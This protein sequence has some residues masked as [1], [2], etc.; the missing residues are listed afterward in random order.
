MADLFDKRGAQFYGA[1][2]VKLTRL[3]NADATKPKIR[4]ALADVAKSASPQDVLIVFLAGHGT[5]LGQRYYFIPHEF[6]AKADQMETDIREQGLPQDTIGDMLAAV[7]ALKR[8]LI[9]DTC[10]SGGA[11]PISRT[12]RDPFAFRGALERLSHATGTFTIAA[13]AADNQAHEVPELKHGLLTYAL[14]AGMGAV[15]NGPLS[16][17]AIRPASDNKVAD[18][19]EW[20]SFAQDKVP[21]LTKLYFGEEQFVGFSGQGNSFPL[22]PVSEK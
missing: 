12:A 7:P 17:Q 8:V 13:A 6:H 10:Q 1:G 4:E 16:G 5:T 21:L 3:L 9:F 20:F 18:V 19:R 15:N 14:L 2:R 11:L 22:L